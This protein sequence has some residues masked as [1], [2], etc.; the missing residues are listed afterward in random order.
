LFFFL[1]FQFKLIENSNNSDK[2]ALQGEKRSETITIPLM[3]KQRREKLKP[4][5]KLLM[6]P[7]I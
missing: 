4:L 7:N 2:E 3:I 5:Q 1:S 6:D